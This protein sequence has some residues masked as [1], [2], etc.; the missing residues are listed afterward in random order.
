[1]EK[2]TFGFDKS[3]SEFAIN[4]EYIRFLGELGLKQ[5]KIDNELIDLEAKKERILS[6]IAESK[7]TTENDPKVLRDYINNA[8]FAL[9]SIEIVYKNLSELQN[10]Y[11]SIEKSLV[12]ISEKSK[13]NLD[14][15]E[16]NGEIKILLQKIEFAKSYEE[17]IKS[18]NKKNYLIINSSLEKTPNYNLK[19]D[20]SVAFESLTLENLTDNPVLKICEK[21]VELPY[22]RKEIEQFMQTYPNEYKAVQDVIVKEFMMNISMLNKHPILSRFKEAY[23]LCRNKEMMSIFDS[24]NFAKS[25]MFRSDIN[26]YIVAAVKSKKQLEDYIKCL[27]ENK[28]DEY[29]HFK[30]VFEVNPLS[31]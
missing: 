29:R 31:V 23:Y 4:E 28:L 1:M 20:R 30:I 24:F 16:I 9:E 8:E 2:T 27:E 22:T 11:R 21:R 25:I 6:K 18:D 7:K 14:R 12:L 19:V 15:N 5:E 10:N 13:L 3:I 17:R 26:P